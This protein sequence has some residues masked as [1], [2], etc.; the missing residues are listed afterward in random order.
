MVNLLLTA[1]GT[2]AV[3]STATASTPSNLLH[4]AMVEFPAGSSCSGQRDNVLNYLSSKGLKPTI[5]TVTDTK[6]FC[7]VSFSLQDHLRN[8]TDAVKDLGGSVSIYPVASRS[9]PKVIRASASVDVPEKIHTL[10]GVDKA[11]SELG[12]TGK[13]V[14][15][16][17]IDSGIYW[18][19]P[20][21]GGCFGPGCKV[22]R[23]WDFVGDSFSATNNQLAPDADPL[24]ECSEES[25]G[26]H[27]AGISA[28]D[29]SH[30][31]QD[32]FITSL[33]WT[34]VA[35]EATLAA[36][37]VF[38]CDGDTTNDVISSAIYRAAEEGADIINMSLGGGPSF[39]DE[40]DAIAVDRVSKA[41]VIVFS[42]AGNDG[43]AG[44]FAASNPA[45][46]LAGFSVAS[47]DNVETAK[48][49]LNVNGQ[50][51]PWGPGV[52]NSSFGSPQSLDIFINN[53]KA[54][55][56][57]VQDDGCNSVGAGAQGKAVLLRWGSGCGSNKR[58]TVAQKAGATACIIYSNGDG[59]IGVT[60][61]SIPTASTTRE[62]GAAILATP[63]KAVISKAQAVFPYATGGTVSDY[64]S[65]GLDA[66]LHMKPDLGAV[67]GQV[68]SCIS[69]TAA[70]KQGYVQPYAA[71]D[72]TS[73]A[74]PYA[75]G[76]AAL[77]L[78][79][80]GKISFDAVKT[81][82]QNTAVPK[83]KFD[84]TLVDSV[85]LQGA[86]L[87]NAYNAATVKTVITPSFLALNDTQFTRKDHYSVVITNN[88][89]KAVSYTFTNVGA[90]TANPFNGKED[91]VQPA[92]EYTSNYASLGFGNK[93]ESVF[94]TVVAP[95]A[96]YQVNVKVTPPVSADPTRFPLYSGYITV[97]NNVDSSVVRVPY[98]GMVGTWMNAPI[99]SVNAPISLAAPTGIY[100]ADGNLVQA[101]ATV[102]VTSANL[103]LFWAIATTTR[104]AYVEVIY[105]GSDRAVKD[106]LNKLGVG[107]NRNQGY[108]VFSTSESGPLDTFLYG[109]GQRIAPTKAQSILAPATY[110]WAGDVLATPD[111]QNI[112]KLPA[113]DYKLRLKGLKHFK[114]PG[115]NGD[116]HY[117]IIETP[118]FHLVY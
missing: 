67:G 104:N 107:H 112:F 81:T 22:A 53:P 16:A 60:G 17:V 92:A 111:S 62:A 74:T 30:I 7:G 88:Y 14:T 96:S 113:G 77:L 26:T 71:Y 75:S 66:E 39:P 78:Q 34:G 46:A 36:Y 80:R 25:H 47:F 51:F 48:F 91:I 68:F 76:V 99:F 45:G 41:G 4:M 70:S 11:R 95:G 10:T 37:R 94:Q 27:V 87:V 102:N 31:T 28:G 106:A 103:Q 63:D 15:I 32:G 18:K 24:D 117:H 97:T 6:L 115:Y 52:L 109:T 98:V 29:A 44:I 54:V 82:L 59:I 33:P 2:L 35:P 3:A 64:S 116:E 1:A 8:A 12:L 61:G 55:A 49:T 93:Q 101:G 19:H 40:S 23:G 50:L 79:K 21:L 38:G 13:G 90:A 43:S 105:T 9:A 58:C 72:G 114:P 83:Q 85:V 84:S 86:G 110:F 5:R 100:G 57:D 89:D 73:M 69:L 42:A 20:A 108:L 65:G 56:D 118:S